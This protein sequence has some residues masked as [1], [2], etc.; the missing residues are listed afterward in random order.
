MVSTWYA[1]TCLHSAMLRSDGVSGSRSKDDI[2][3]PMGP[4]RTIVNSVCQEPQSEPSEAR[5][6]APRVPDAVVQS[7]LQ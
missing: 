4:T 2:V 5:S 3:G 7:M 6:G 1:S